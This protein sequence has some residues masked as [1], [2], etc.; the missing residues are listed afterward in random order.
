MRVG[1]FVVGAFCQEKYL[2]AVSGHVQIPL[3]TAKI[4]VEQ[5]HDVTLIT[6]RARTTDILP[7]NFPETITVDVVEHASRTWPNR[8]AR[9]GKSVIQ[10]WQLH[11]LLKKKSFDVVHFFGGNNTGLML[12]CLKY[13]GVKTLAFYTPIKRPSDLSFAFRSNLMRILFR[14]IDRIIATTNYVSDGWGILCGA[15]KCT[16]LYPGIVKDMP[17]PSEMQTR[18]SILFW[19][20]A[21][22]ENGA[23]LAIE[24]F[25]E[26]AP[27]NPDMRFVFAIRPHD[28]LEGD[29]LDLQASVENVEVYIY[30][31]PEGISLATLLENALFVVQPFRTLSIN[32]QYSILETLYSG[33]PVISTTIESNE[34]L[35]KD[36]R[37]GLLIPPNDERALIESIERLLGDR[38]LIAKMSKVA[39]PET[40]A[41]WNWEE[42]G[43]G[44]LQVYEN[45]KS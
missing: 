6:T 26:L 27:K 25:R 4:L 36:Q 43:K 34:E 15:G 17:K 20:N 7:A 35:I 8:G 32:P 37:T 22:Y 45:G 14:R 16:F 31:Y 3:M 40:R 28:V 19:R 10:A 2:D 38:E 18:N 13:T 23:D 12:S 39:L 33:I 21:G 30:P 9:R 24:A 29:M 42:F 44:L 41:R 5:G 11:S 1:L